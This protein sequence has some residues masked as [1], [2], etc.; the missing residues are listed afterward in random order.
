MTK[1]QIGEGDGVYALTLEGHAGYN[2][3]NDVVCAALSA[4]VYALVGYLHNAG[5][6]LYGMDEETVEPGHVVLWFRG[7]GQVGAAFRMA[8][9]GLLQIAR[10]YPAYVTAATNQNLPQDTLRQEIAGL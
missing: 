2:P 7:D 1:V 4:T 5:A 9:I 6:H 8:A 3:G 10:Q